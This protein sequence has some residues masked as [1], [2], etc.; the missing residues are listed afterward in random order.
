MNKLTIFNKLE[1]L[2]YTY[3]YGAK[4]K[5]LLLML[6]KRGA[7]I[8][9]DHSHRSFDYLLPAYF[10]HLNITFFLFNYRPLTQAIISFQ[11]MRAQPTP[12]L[13][14]NFRGSYGRVRSRSV[15]ITCDQFCARDDLD[16][17]KELSIDCI[18]FT[19]K[20][21][22]FHA[23]LLWLPNEKTKIKGMHSSCP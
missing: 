16:E 22:E 18:F 17:R 1:M 21:E 3:I 9:G 11:S 15:L 2:Q 6:V 4:R 8:Y 7:E 10:A 19:L 13:Q 14:S 23:F 5:V 20:C 12:R